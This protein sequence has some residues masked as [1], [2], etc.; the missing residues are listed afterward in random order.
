M[1]LAALDRDNLDI[2]TMRFLDNALTVG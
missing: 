2:E 1:A